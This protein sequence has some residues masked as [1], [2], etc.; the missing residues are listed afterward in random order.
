MIEK[1]IG[2][3][4]YELTEKDWD[5]IAS[6]RAIRFAK[7]MSL[8]ET[9]RTAVELHLFSFLKEFPDIEELP[10][11]EINKIERLSNLEKSMKNPLNPLPPTGLELEVK[12]SLISEAK[13][14]I[15]TQFDLPK[16]PEQLYP[17]YFEFR[18][19][20]SYSAEIQ[21]R[22]IQEL[23]LS[24]V[25]P[26]I[27]NNSEIKFGDT[28]LHVNFGIPRDIRNYIYIKDASTQ[29][30]KPNPNISILNAASV[31]AFAS[32]ERLGSR[33]T[34]QS[35]RTNIGIPSLKSGLDRL[36]FRMFEMRDKSTFRM[37]KELQ[38]MVGA[39]FSHFR[40][41]RSDTFSKK[42]DQIPSLVWEQFF[43]EVCIIFESF[44]VDPYREHRDENK[45]YLKKFTEKTELVK[46]LRSVFTKYA[47]KMSQYIH[48]EFPLYRLD[49]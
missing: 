23:F 33:K 4:T 13:L 25:I 14:D 16:G 32:P 22:I 17:D 12:W 30:S 36:E 37:I 27:E 19:K 40:K 44:E 38:L 42:R 1:R 15:L 46:K 29:T 28:S 34:E 9:S 8:E 26:S 35:F 7:S 49:D 45:D 2:Q 24:G 31:I 3:K 18:P 21:A 20:F 6:L 47:I 41:G 43:D 11:S 10:E 5:S 39:M 48:E